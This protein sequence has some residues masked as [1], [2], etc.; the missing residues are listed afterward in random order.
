MSYRIHI[1]P[2]HL[3][4]E[5]KNNLDS[6]LESNWI[7]PVGSMLN[8]WEAR[9]NQDTNSYSV[10]T[11]SGEAAL[12][13]ALRSVG[14]KE[15][16]RVITATH[17]C[18]ATVNAILHLGATPIFV[19]SESETWNIDPALVEEL[20]IQE[21]ERQSLSSIQ[22]ILPVH[23]YGMPAKLGPLQ[24]ICRDF[25]IPLVEDAAEAVGSTF[26]NRFIGTIGDAGMLSFNGNKIITSGGGGAFLS[27]EESKAI[28]VLKWATQAKEKAPWY[29]HEEVGHSYRLSN[30]LAA[31]GL[32]QWEVL[33]ERVEGRISNY[34]RY[35]QLWDKLG[36]SKF[37]ETQD[38]TD[39]VS[40]RWLSAFVLHSDLGLQPH[41]LIEKLAEKGVEARR[42]WKP[43]HRQPVYSGYQAVTNGTAD[44]LFE[45][46][47]C[48]PSGTGYS[49]ADWELISEALTEIFTSRS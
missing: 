48:L 32:G 34:N 16:G 4:E 5:S 39:G 19:D 42:F 38:N 33:A 40:N 35:L 1:S 21:Q 8:E 43:M 28:Q 11:T 27:K 15:G 20:L 3:S 29:Q 36:V 31:I 37:I 25:Q 26:Q 9:I 44:Y 13:L 22:A 7:A 30:V 47:V 14:V 17:T 6:A 49:E 45:H 10:L 46:G 2:P 41:V 24:R 12:E 23:I 18:N